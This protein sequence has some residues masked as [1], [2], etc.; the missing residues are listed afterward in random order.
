MAHLS[1]PPWFADLGGLCCT[2][3]WLSSVGINVDGLRAEHLTI[4]KC[5]CSSNN[6]IK[7]RCLAGDKKDTVFYT[8]MTLF[9]LTGFVTE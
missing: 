4:V 1:G 2:V 9:Y 3:V 5:G 7:E 8:H 6:E